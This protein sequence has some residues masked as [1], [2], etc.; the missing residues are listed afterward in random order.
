MI[1][2]FDAAA[3]AAAAT[4]ASTSAADPDLIDG[5]RRAARGGGGGGGGR[6][7][8]SAPSYYNFDAASF[9][10]AMRKRRRFAI[11]GRVKLVSAVTAMGTGAMPCRRKASG[12][13]LSQAHI[14]DVLCANKCP[15]TGDH[16][17]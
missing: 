15:I 5:W 8:R 11:V 16:S 3:A 2:P 9:A 17:K 10:V 6:T 12:A 13:V 4:F 14:S 7:I 1:S